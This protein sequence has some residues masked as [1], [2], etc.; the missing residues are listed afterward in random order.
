M[1]RYVSLFPVIG[2]SGLTE[3]C[4]ITGEHIAV[5]PCGVGVYRAKDA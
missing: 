2:D 1:P 3:G 5:R 4:K